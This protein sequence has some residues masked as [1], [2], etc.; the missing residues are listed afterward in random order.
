MAR[1]K[2]KEFDL[3]ARIAKMIA[4][5]FTP[6]ASNAERDEGMAD[7]DVSLQSLPQRIQIIL[8][9]IKHQPVKATTMNYLI[10]YDIEKNKVRAL[11]AKYLLSQG[12][13]RVQ[14]SVFLSHSNHKKFD[15]IKNTLAEINEIYENSDS[16]ILIPLNVSD[17]RSMK[18]I[19]KNVNIEQ[20]IDP[21]NTVFI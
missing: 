18:L 11:I 8:G 7:D 3:K 5:G 2:H 1:P 4:A 19:G 12:C 15:A 10:L 6:G 14:K 17:A 13:I 9:I 21:P 20:I 16:I